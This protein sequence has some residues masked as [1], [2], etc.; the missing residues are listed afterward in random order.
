MSTT[1]CSRLCRSEPRSTRPCALPL[2][3]RDS[4]RHHGKARTLYR[5]L[6]MS[7][8][9]AVSRTRRAHVPPQRPQ[10]LHS[11]VCG[12]RG[13]RFTLATFRSRGWQRPYESRNKPKR[14]QSRALSP[15]GG[16]PDA[17][18]FGGGREFLPVAI[19]AVQSIHPPRPVADWWNDPGCRKPP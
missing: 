9:W 13:L 12:H 14:H 6:P 11:P 3:S 7:R 15:Q 17:P 1:G 8:R 19:G 2:P 18:S 16:R 10:S 5:H 4:T